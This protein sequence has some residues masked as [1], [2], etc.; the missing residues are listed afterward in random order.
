MTAWDS[1]DKFSKFITPLKNLSDAL[2][3]SKTAQNAKYENYKIAIAK[4]IMLNKPIRVNPDTIDPALIKK[5]GE[6]TIKIEL[7]ESVEK[8]NGNLS[9]Y[10]FTLDQTN[11]IISHTYNLNSN[12]TDITELLN[13]VKKDGYEIKDIN[14]EQSSLEEIFIKLIKENNNELVR[15]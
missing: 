11:K 1:A 8:I 14:T 5:L 2:L 4:S 3:G 13:D 12:T 7:F 6:K 9:K 15:N 10:N